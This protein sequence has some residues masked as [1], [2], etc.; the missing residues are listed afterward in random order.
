[1]ANRIERPVFYE[2]QILGASDLEAVGDYSRNQQARHNRYLHTWG[3]AKG[4][5][6]D[7]KDKKTDDGQDY[8]EI[9]LDAR[10]GD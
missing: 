7:P 1:M 6:L 8:K 3:I 2:G 4:L 9:T 5:T 10:R